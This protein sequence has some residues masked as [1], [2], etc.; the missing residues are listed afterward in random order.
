MLKEHAVGRSIFPPKHC[1]FVW[2][3]AQWI[4]RRIEAFEGS[5]HVKKYMD[6]PERCVMQTGLEQTCVAPSTR[7][8]W[9]RGAK[10]PCVEGRAGHRLVAEQRRLACDLDRH[11]LELGFRSL[12]RLDAA[13]L[14]VTRRAKR[15]GWWVGHVLLVRELFREGLGEARRA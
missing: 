14:C 6:E 13:A 12:Y 15:G 9:A 8:W 11:R 10:T 5:K 2:G 4:E 3:A 1:Q 7:G